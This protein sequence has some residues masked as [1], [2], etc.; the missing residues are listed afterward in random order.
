MHSVERRVL[1]LSLLLCTCNISAE[2][3]QK[4][5]VDVPGSN[6]VSESSKQ[7]DPS[8]ATSEITSNTY[9]V[10]EDH[11]DPDFVSHVQPS[12]DAF[13]AVVESDE[14][15]EIDSVSELQADSA[16]NPESE[17]QENESFESES[18]QVDVEATEAAKSFTLLN[19]A[20]LVSDALDSE[21]LDDTSQT[22]ANEFPDPVDYQMVDV[23]SVDKVIAENRKLFSI[24]L[25]I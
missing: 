19:L 12:D 17:V 23:A 4:P 10:E 5:P 20:E 21:D 22:Q 1:T 18:D 3:L 24:I 25:K 16:R 7:Y 2:Q 8:T 9:A 14:P 15:V 13:L 6:D 11:D